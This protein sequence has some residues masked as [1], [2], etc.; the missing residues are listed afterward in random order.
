MGMLLA[1]R[2][3]D[4]LVSAVSD[5]PGA[6][7]SAEVQAGLDVLREWDNTVAAEARG[8]VLFEAWYLAYAD[9]VGEDGVFAE[10]W[11][12]D[13][14]L[15]TPRSMGDPEAAVAAFVVAVGEVLEKWGRLDVPWGAVHRVRVG[16]ADL[17]VG[18]CTGAYGCF[19]VLWFEE[20]ED[21]LRK[22]RGGDGWVFAVEF[23]E[24]PRAYSILAYG[25][26]ARP[27]SPYRESQAPLF[28]RNEMK[29][30]AFT[31]ADIEARTI[32]RY[33]PG[34]EGAPTP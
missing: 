9:V 18:G 25:Q 24:V 21:G 33:H 11:D 3:K 10:P 8:A 5:H 34:E 17:P 19:R 26:S 29:P 7:G 16:S 23:G 1:D 27:D 30:V 20:D 13:R 4:E 2:L 28:A 32:R 15:E 14:P 31:E 12:E 22:V 6:S